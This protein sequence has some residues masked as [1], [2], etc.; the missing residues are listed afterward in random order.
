[1]FVAGISSVDRTAIRFVP[2]R[3]KVN[4]WYYVHKVLRPLIKK[5]I[6]KLFGSRAHL[7]VLHQ[8]SAS[9]PKTSATVQWL[10]ANGYKFI[11]VGDWPA[12]SPD[13]NPINYAI[14]KIFKQCLWRR[15]ARNLRGSIRAMKKRWK[16]I[17]KNLCI[18]TLQSWEGRVIKKLEN[19]YYQIKHVK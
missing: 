9:A 15:K 3:I 19:H 1:M 6:P 14:N 7:V 16:N 13:L 12:N 17:S 10:K 2:P 11:P 8:D 5:Y 4:S 18:G